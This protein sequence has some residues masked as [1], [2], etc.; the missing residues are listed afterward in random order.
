MRGEGGAAR[1]QPMS[2]AVH[3][4]PNK[5]WRSNS[6]FNL[7]CTAVQERE[8]SVAEQYSQASARLAVLEAQAAKTA[9][10]R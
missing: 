7:W 1:S 5:L 2:T 3:M 4:S 10:L 9:H 8:R 6:I